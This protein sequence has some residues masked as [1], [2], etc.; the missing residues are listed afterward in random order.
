MSIGYA[1]EPGS[2]GYDFM[3]IR[4]IK[5]VFGLVDKSEVVEAIVTRLSENIVYRKELTAKQINAVIHTSNINSMLKKRL[6]F[7]FTTV[8]IID[9]VLKGQS[10]NLYPT[11]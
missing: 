4:T 1:G 3:G 5:N 7:T 10:L 8:R 6:K 11:N 2:I 9:N